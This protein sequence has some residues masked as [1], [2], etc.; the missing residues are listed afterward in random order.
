VINAMIVQGLKHT[1]KRDRPFIKYPDKIHPYDVESGYS[2]P[3]GHASTAFATATSLT[4]EF[5]KWY[6]AVPAYAWA[7]AVGYA[8]LYQGEHYPTD[9][10]AGAAIGAGSAWLSHWLGNKIFTPKKK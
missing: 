8:R 9:V 7:T 5:K 4:L 2:F 3:S 1:V 10:F 6:V